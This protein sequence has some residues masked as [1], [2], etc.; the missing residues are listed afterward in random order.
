MAED[1]IVE[2]VRETRTRFNEES[3]YD[4][5]QIAARA[6]EFARSLGLSVCSL[7]PTARSAVAAV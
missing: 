3:N 1:P 6:A 5:R 7:Q 4:L 2:E